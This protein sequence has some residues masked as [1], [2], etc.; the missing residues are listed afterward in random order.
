MAV[1]IILLS[2]TVFCHFQHSEAN[3]YKEPLSDNEDNESGY[4]FSR[5]TL[6]IFTKFRLSNSITYNKGSTGNIEK[7]ELV[8]GS[9]ENNMILQDWKR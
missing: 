1:F 3:Y 6:E 5:D 9:Y 7:A 8:S 4:D 2:L